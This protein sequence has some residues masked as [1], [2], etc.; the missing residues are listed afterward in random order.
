[1]I[2]WDK[3]ETALGVVANQGEERNVCI[4]FDGYIDSLFRVV[5]A[6]T[7][8]DAFETYSTITEFAH[9]VANAAGRSADMEL[10]P[11][12]RRMGGNAPLMAESMGCQGL[13][14]R[15]IGTMGYPEPEDL[16]SGQNIHFTAESVA[17]CATCT[18]FEFSDG[19]LMFGNNQSLLDLD[20]ESIVKVVGLEKLRQWYRGCHLWAMVNWS[21]L[22]N[23]NEILEGLIRDVVESCREEKLF[24]FDLADPSGRSREDL[25]K[26]FSLMKRLETTNRVVLSM[27]ENESLQ[28]AGALGMEAGEAAPCD[29]A[30]AIRETTGIWMASIHGLDYAVAATRERSVREEGIFVPVPIISTGGGDHFNGGFAAALVCGLEPEEALAFGNLVSSCYVS[31]GKSPTLQDLRKYL[32]NCQT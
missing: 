19:K 4:G 25:R 12:S 23:S 9:R 14:V 29:R 30:A 8:R 6:R 27:N 2:S 15:C 11:V 21:F 5:K 18:A 10:Q 28:V 24:F 3:M 20:W 26:L 7:S 31:G 13:S 17:P 1:M 22:M 16:F 32:T